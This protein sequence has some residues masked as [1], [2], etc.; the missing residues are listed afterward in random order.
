MISYLMFH[1][2]KSRGVLSI[3]KQYSQVLDM[4]VSIRVN[5]YFGAHLNLWFLSYSFYIAKT[6]SFNLSI[7]ESQWSWH[8]NGIYH[9]T[10]SYMKHIQTS[11]AIPQ[12]SACYSYASW[13]T[14][15]VECT[16]ML[17]PLFM[18]PLP[19]HVQGSTSWRFSSVNSM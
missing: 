6:K 17:L 13:V 10:H 11:I 16:A 3:S 9:R 7:V 15:A 18:L 5:C 1:W 2:F 12:I 4:L 14:Y 8:V 19:H